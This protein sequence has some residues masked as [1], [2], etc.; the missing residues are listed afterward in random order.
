MVIKPHSGAAKEGEWN[1]PEMRARVRS[2]EDF[3]YFSKIFAWR[4]DGKDETVKSSYR[5]IHHFVSADGDP[6]EP[7]AQACRTGI[8][9]LNG[10]RGGT[11]LRGDDR[12]GVYEHL[13]RHLEEAGIEPPEL[14]SH[15]QLARL[16]KRVGGA[17]LEIRSGS[18]IATLESSG[19]GSKAVL[20]GYASVYDTPSIDLGGW[21]EV[22]ARGAFDETLASLDRRPVKCLWNHNSDIVLG[23]TDSGTLRLE[24]DGRGL[25][26]MID[27]PSWASPYVESVRRG[28]VTQMSIGFVVRQQEWRE[29]HD[30]SLV[31]IVRSVDLWEVSPVAFPAYEE[32]T[33][34]AGAQRSAVDPGIYRAR[35]RLLR[36]EGGTT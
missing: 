29:S 34:T 12:A 36:L 18:N 25:I 26:A 22:I 17:M 21:R 8:A 11:V 3:Q 33:I 2:P 23:S 19:P 35:L 5:F 13:A 16:V 6:G 4:D 28:D 30:G 14:A 31:R 9:V 10:A 15:E 1:G 20:T 32:T 27:P 7:S 24:S